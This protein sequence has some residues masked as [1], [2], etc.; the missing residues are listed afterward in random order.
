MPKYLDRTIHT[1]ACHL[2]LVTTEKDMLAE[3]RRLRVPRE[4]WPSF[5][6]TKRSTTRAQV[7]YLEQGSGAKLALVSVSEALKGDGLKVAK[8]LCHEAVHVWQW[9]TELIGGTHG[10]SKEFEAYAIEH[11]F[12]ILTEEYAKQVAFVSNRSRSKARK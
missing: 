9:H 5:P 10:Q 6:G 2:K 4:D 11:I 3:M 12:D 8:A 7:N 1:L